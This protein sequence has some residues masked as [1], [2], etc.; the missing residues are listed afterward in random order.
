[1]VSRNGSRDGNRR[2]SAHRPGSACLLAAALCLLP[3]GCASWD[4]RGHGFGDSLATWGQDY[5]SPSPGLQ[6]AGFD[7]RSREIEQS[8]GVP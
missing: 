7:R 3:V 8:L 2:L 4:P 1:M 6:S 5:R